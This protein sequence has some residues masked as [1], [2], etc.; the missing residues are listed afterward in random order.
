M[1]SWRYSRGQSFEELFLKESLKVY[2]E[3]L[4]K[5]STAFL[6]KNLQNTCEKNCEW[7]S[8]KKNPCSI[9]CRISGEIFWAFLGD[10]WRISR[11]ILGG[12]SLKWY[13][14]SMKNTW[15]IPG[16][17]KNP[18]IAILLPVNFQLLHKSLLGLRPS[19][20]IACFFNRHLVL[21]NPSCLPSSSVLRIIQ[22]LPK[23]IIVLSETTAPWNSLF[24]LG[25]NKIIIFSSES[26]NLN[27]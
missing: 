13:I 5:E 16:S 22:F 8:E 14:K 17:W 21:R 2:V 25:F 23:S 26:P 4:L 7:I 1:S 18:G 20:R 12:I 24:R 6:K 3:K 19:L 27:C 11:R 9:Y 15:W 10:L